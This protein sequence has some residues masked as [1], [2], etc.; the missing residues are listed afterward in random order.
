MATQFICGIGCGFMMTHIVIFATDMGYSEMIGA[1]FL[2]VQGGA[3]LVGVL[4]TGHMSDRIARNRVLAL[5]HFIRSVSFVVVVISILLGGGS[6]WMFYVAMAIFGFGW[7]TTAPLSFGLVADLFG[8][9]RMGTMIGV[10]V[11]CH[12]IG[13]AI[14]AYAGGVTFE[15]THSYYSFFLIQGILEFLAAVFAFAM[16]RKTVR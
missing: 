12:M 13:M 16:K 11:S 3:N 9:V 6:L 1:T 5:T 8:Y 10:T 2:S 7:F 4:V 15:L 14:G